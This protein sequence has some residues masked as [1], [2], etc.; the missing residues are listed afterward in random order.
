SAAPWRPPSRSSARRPRRHLISD[1]GIH[2]IGPGRTAVLASFGIETALDIDKNRIMQLKGFK[3]KWTDRLLEWRQEIESQFGFDPS[4][5]THLEGQKE[6]EMKGG[7]EPS[8][9]GA[10]APPC[11][12]RPA[13]DHSPCQAELQ[14]LYDRIKPL[15]CRLAQARADVV[16]IPPGL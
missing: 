12:A 8:A 14:S 7:Q 16:A 5:P 2:G 6:V 4:A 10:E 15:V 11:E 9:I 13:D 1:A 3:E